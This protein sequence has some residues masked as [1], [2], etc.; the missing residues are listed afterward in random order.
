MNDKQDDLYVGTT[1]FR[2]YSTNRSNGGRVS[3]DFK[4]NRL[5][6]ASGQKRKS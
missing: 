2:G 4:L 1:A 3:H 5:V 6:L